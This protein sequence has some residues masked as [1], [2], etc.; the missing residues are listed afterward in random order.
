MNIS[1]RRLY[2]LITSGLAVVALAGAPRPSFAASF[3]P[4]SPWPDPAFLDYRQCHGRYDI[5][6]LNRLVP[7]ARVALWLPGTRSVIVD[8]ERHCITVTVES[9]GD[10]RLAEL[11]MRGVAVPRRAVFLRLDR[12]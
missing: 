3:G 8:Q 7:R 1:A 2:R 10:G 9:F 4:S 5:Q 6:E 11:V 12:G